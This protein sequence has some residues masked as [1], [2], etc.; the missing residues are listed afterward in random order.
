MKYFFILGTNQA[1]SLAE[2]DSVIGGIDKGQI[3]NKTVFIIDTE[4]KID[5]KKLISRLGGTIKIGIIEKEDIAM[6]SSDMMGAIKNMLAPSEGKY[7]FGISNYAKFASPS[8]DKQVA[9]T[10][11]KYLKDKGQSCRWV[12]AKEKVLS[13]VVVEQNLMKGRGIE[14]VIVG[15][16]KKCF[17][18]K[19]LAVQPFKDLATRDYGRPS[20]DD[21][22]GMLPPKLAQ[23]MINLSG[24]KQDDFLLDPFCG[25]GTIISEAMVMG[26]K[27][28]IASDLSDKAIA[29]TKNN[30][31]WIARKFDIK[32][33][34]EIFQSDVRKLIG[35]IKNKSID[36][37]VMEPYLGPQRG[38][39]DQVKLQL[40]LNKLY[41]EAISI[42]D[43]ILSKNGKIVM[44]WPIRNLG[45]HVK[46]SKHS[47]GHSKNIVLS[48]SLGGF[49]M[50]KLLDDE[51]R[52]ALKNSFSKR[53]NIIYG[54]EGQK[55][56]REIVI[57][58]RN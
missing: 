50:V 38:K 26:Y 1:L 43:K 24:A 27:N 21:H 32:T 41:T 23:I 6:Y 54:R 46:N 17:L 51:Q 20:R 10:I 14:V 28:I 12:V 8:K 11:K 9:M 2:L 35:T 18:G 7:K 15:D 52:Q 5:A 4:K 25:S 13:S 49:K 55:V 19:T 16:Y 22:S 39:I 34:P 45:D 29:D 33:K 56:W 44:I 47:T 37:I 3:Y 30:T 48:P 40:E 58:E 36:A 57:L 42:F 31:A 53:G